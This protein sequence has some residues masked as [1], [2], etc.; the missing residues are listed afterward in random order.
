M[1]R[2]GNGIGKFRGKA[3]LQE[4]NNFKGN[5]GSLVPYQINL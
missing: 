4:R 2:G 5:D 3:F 1:R